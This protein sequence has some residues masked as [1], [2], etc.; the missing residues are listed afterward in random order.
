ML[1]GKAALIAGVAAAA[2]VGVLFWQNH[3]LQNR[4]ADTQAAVGATRTA[5]A[6]QAETIDSLQRQA[7]AAARAREALEHRLSEITADKARADKRIAD[8]HGRLGKLAAENPAAVRRIINRAGKRLMLDF[9][10]ATRRPDV[11]GA[12]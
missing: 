4:L 2:V 8:A 1:G 9:A 7:A 5:N 12:D 11:A 6:V 3:A 10:D